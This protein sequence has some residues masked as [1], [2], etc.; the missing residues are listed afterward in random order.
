MQYTL[1]VTDRNLTIVGDPIVCWTSI[2]VS[3][4]FNQPGSGQAVMP[5]SPWI[6]EQ[7]Q[8]GNRVVVI[9]GPDPAVDYPGRVLLAGP[10]EERL[11]ERSDDGANG[12][13]GKLTVTFA[14]DLAWIAGRI[15]YPNPGKAPDQQDVEAWTFT[16]N[17]EQ[18][19]RT[20]VD[21]NAG[22]RA[23]PER[24]VP[25][26]VL[27]ATAGIG[28]TVTVKTR[29]EVVTDVLRTTAASGG[30]LGF[31]TRQDD[32]QILFEVYRPDDRSAEVRYSFDL[33]NVKYVGYTV[34]SSKVSAAI[35]GGQGA[36]AD[37]FVLE[38][39]DPASVAAWGRV[40]TLVSRPGNDAVAE[41][42]KAGDEALAEGGQSARLAATTMDTPT[43]RYGVHY[44][45][46]STVAMEL[47]PG[48]VVT[49]RVQTVHLQAYATA[50]EVVTS[51]IGSQAASYDPAW[52]IRLRDIDSRVG[53]LERT[54]Q[55]A[56][57]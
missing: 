22:P 18:A 5:G 40:E 32:R 57:P 28:S 10:I 27:G 26:L 55:P 8:T 49:D 54:V 47:W 12:G 19:M 36:G 34:E 7:M 13:D 24:R 9:R 4:R 21:L 37:R 50:G 3:L 44:D 33:G 11:Y 23:L 42:Q 20:L 2:D 52:V 48:E 17:A 31:R 53:R 46:G 16:G 1:L 35:V 15:T 29:L 51:T 30:D 38:R 6:R 43:Q 14:D 56:R 39:T 45:V 25:Q 41:L